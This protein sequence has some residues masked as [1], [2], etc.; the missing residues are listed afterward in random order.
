MQRSAT[1][2]LHQKEYDQVFQRVEDEG[3]DVDAPQPIDLIVRQEKRG[4]FDA[5]DQKFD[6]PHVYLYFPLSVD[7]DLYRF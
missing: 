4:V 5:T 6:F 2:E 1:I 3:D 7:E